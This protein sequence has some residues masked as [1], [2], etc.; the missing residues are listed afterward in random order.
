MP[1]ISPSAEWHL[2]EVRHVDRRRGVREFLTEDG[3]EDGRMYVERRPGVIT[4]VRQANSERA[5]DVRA[6]PLTPSSARGGPGQPTPH[7]RVQKHAR[8]LAEQVA[9]GLTRD[10]NQRG[11]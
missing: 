1:G 3:R 11:G 8:R 5:S 4:P 9:E 7:E 10:L 6:H 2:H